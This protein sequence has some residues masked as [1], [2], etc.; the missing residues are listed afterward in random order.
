MSCTRMLEKLRGGAGSKIDPLNREDDRRRFYRIRCLSILLPLAII[1]ALSSCLDTDSDQDGLIDDQD[2]C[3]SVM[4]KTNNGCPLPVK[5]NR[6]HFYLD[7]SASMGG[8]FAGPTE[9]KTIISDLAVKVD[10][11]VS[12]IDIS[13]IADKTIHYPKT[14]SEFTTAMATTPI[15]LQKSSEL[16]RMIRQVAMGNGKDDVS[17]LASDCILSFPNAAVKANPNINRDNAS[18][19]LKNNIY[20]SFFDLKAKGYG[21]VVYAFHSKFYG[22]YYDFQ[23]RK[24]KLKGAARPF[25][26]WVIARKETL[27]K[28]S[29]D[30]ERVS[31]FKPEKVMYFGLSEK[32]V[33][34]FKILPELERRGNWSGSDSGVSEIEITKG[35]PI[36]IGLVLNLQSLPRY[37]QE[38]N[39]LQNNL[40]V[41]PN[42]C[43]IKLAYKQKSEVDGSKLHSTE[44]IKALEQAS[45]VLLVSIIDMKLPDAS[46]QFSLPQKYDTWDLGWSTM[47][48]QVLSQQSKT[49]AFEHLINGVKQAFGTSDKNFIDFSLTL[50]K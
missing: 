2:Q 4:A 7:N 35:Q 27:R 3:P 17:L 31:S 25:Y 37:A 42:G 20:A 24:A 38:M 32:P 13:Y 14:I 44:Q 8:Y 50:N 1:L 18:S 16:H 29:A 15:A 9:F 23:N 48:D 28:F 46:I 26:I 21:A 43:L 30:L 12:P 39:Y 36:Q 41:K 45:H 33:T 6:V 47:D 19:V 40:I 22:T 5:I 34:D 10:K 11:E 49:F